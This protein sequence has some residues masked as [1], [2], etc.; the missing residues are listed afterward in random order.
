MT[1]CDHKFIDSNRCAK[2]GMVGVVPLLIEQ[3]KEAL[4]TIESLGAQADEDLEAIKIAKAILTNYR[5]DRLRIS[6]AE[7][8]L[9]MWLEDNMTYEA[10]AGR[11]NGY[12][13]K[14]V[15]Q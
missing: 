11:T 15:K 2:C 12:F 13:A 3:L 9:Q 6:A 1:T 14:W 8:L 5:R 10:C 7:E 4:A